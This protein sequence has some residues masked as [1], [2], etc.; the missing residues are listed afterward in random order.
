MHSILK[1]HE[2]AKH[3]GVYLVQLWFNATSIDN[4]GCFKKSFT[5]VFQILLW[6]VLR[7]RLRLNVY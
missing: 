3:T 6:L 7:K 1:C 5:I 2:V 4:V